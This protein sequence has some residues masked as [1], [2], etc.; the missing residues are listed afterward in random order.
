MLQEIKSKA[1]PKHLRRFKCGVCGKTI[2]ARDTQD[3]EI[4]CC[5]TILSGKGTDTFKLLKVRNS[6]D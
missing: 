4:E 2:Y 6:Y 3:I 5:G 1:L